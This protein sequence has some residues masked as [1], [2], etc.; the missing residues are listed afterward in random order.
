MAVVSKT[1]GAA[2]FSLLMI[3]GAASVAF[4]QLEPPEV[5]G[6]RGAPFTSINPPPGVPSHGEGPEWDGRPPDGIE[7]LAVDVFTTTDFYRDRELWTDPRYWR[8][9]SPRQMA[10][11]RS[12]GAGRGTAD[13]RIG[14]D[15]PVSARWGDCDVDW[16]RE[17]IVSP[18]PFTSA[19]EHYQALMADAQSRGG[20]THHTYETMPEWD[21]TYG[22]YAPEG[23]LVWNY[24]RANQIPTVLSL[25]TPQHQQY[26][27]QQL[28]H[29]GVRAA[30]AWSASYCWPEGFMRQW[31]TG[32][33]RASRIVVT[34]DLVMF[35]SAVMTRVVQLGREFP[36]GPDVLQWYGDT[37]GFWDGDALITMTS[38]IQ[39]WNQ[40]SSWEWSDKLETV[41][42]LTPVHDAAGELIGIDWEAVIYDSGALEE[43]VRILRHRNYQQPLAEASRLGKDECSTRLYPVDGFATQVAPGEVIEYRVPDMLDRPW[44]QIWEEFERDMDAPGQELD[45]GFD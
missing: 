12:G 45:L 44:A 2:V 40:H 23:R 31:A 4:A 24:M 9:N 17:N 35:M 36:V 20:P 38:N 11:L 15:P 8:C 5:P 30:H 1:P 21:G 42:I 13:P 10:D 26:L 28:Y 32:G 25:L 29:E 6:L 39:G 14:G 34:P 37:I 16:P 7:P 22:V 19:A 41:E 27:V 43:P 18:Y 3:V 33:T